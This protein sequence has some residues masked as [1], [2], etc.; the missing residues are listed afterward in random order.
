M[1]CLPCQSATG[2][3]GSCGSPDPF[4][5]PPVPVVTVV[6]G[7]QGATGA[8]GPQGAQGFRG[9]TGATG[10]QGAT[11]PQGSIGI[12]GPQGSTGIQGP[13]G[14]QSMVGFFSG[15]IWDPSTPP[16][17]K[18]TN[19]SD[20]K[21]IDFGQIGFAS[22]TYLFHLEMQIGWAGNLN[23]G[24]GGYQPYLNGNAWFSS[25][26]AFGTAALLQNFW[27]GRASTNVGTV[28]YGSA[29]SY[30]HWFVATVNQGDNLFLGTG[31][32]WFLL[33][34]QLS[35]FIIPPYNVTSPGF[36]SGNNN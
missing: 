4:C 33:G 17:Q 30:G 23:A 32:D 13:T 2:A 20:A 11:G 6:A 9:A 21:A 22:G 25:G 27:W 10:A 29:Q 14:V 36:I 15:A 8:T 5:T 34:A 19:L 31:S 26:T 3:T 18:L 1:S 16:G 35:A 24:G 7:P 28:N 12:T